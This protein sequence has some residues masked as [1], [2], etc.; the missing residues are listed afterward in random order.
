MNETQSK[1][2]ENQTPTHEIQQSVHE[3]QIERAKVNDSAQA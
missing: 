2:R 3:Y 1:A